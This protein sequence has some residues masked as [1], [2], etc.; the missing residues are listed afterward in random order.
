MPQYFLCLN[1][2]VLRIHPQRPTARWNHPY[3]LKWLLQID[4][5]CKRWDNSK[6][7]NSLLIRFRSQY[8]YD[9]KQTFKSCTHNASDWYY[10]LDYSTT[11][12]SLF[13]LSI[14]LVLNFVFTLSQL[15]MIVKVLMPYV[16]V[17]IYG[18]Y[19][20]SPARYFYRLFG[21]KHFPFTTSYFWGI[22][23]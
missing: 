11:T 4:L 9:L 14:L 13:L 5:E 17:L 18:D 6:D 16:W 8:S 2:I 22:F 12:P 21:F 1:F 10:S 3:L 20:R 15:L 23:L 7:L 19:F